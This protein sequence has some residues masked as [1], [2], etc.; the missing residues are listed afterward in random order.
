MKELETATVGGSLDYA[1]KDT[2]LI[3]TLS[4][5]QTITF[6]IDYVTGTIVQS[7]PFTI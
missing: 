4:N 7:T 6:G 2:P 1:P 5:G 3:V